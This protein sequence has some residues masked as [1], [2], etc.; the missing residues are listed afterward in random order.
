MRLAAAVLLVVAFVGGA[1]AKS[2]HSGFTAEEIAHFDK[3]AVGAIIHV[4]QPAGDG[5]NTCAW[6][7]QKT[8]PDTVKMLGA[9]QCTL[10]A[11]NVVLPELKYK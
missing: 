8:G 5:C 10:L 9:G 6:E 2:F 11:C 3:A 1:S 4:I 7:Y